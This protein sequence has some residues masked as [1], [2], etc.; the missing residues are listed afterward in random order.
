MCAR[1]AWTRSGLKWELRATFLH[2]PFRSTL[3]AT[4]STLTISIP[5][6]DGSARPSAAHSGQLGAVLREIKRA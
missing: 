2:D 6:E 3:K 5:S 1:V 4:E